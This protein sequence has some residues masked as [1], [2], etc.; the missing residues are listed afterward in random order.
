MSLNA[1]QPEPDHGYSRHPAVWALVM[2]DMRER[3]LV[4]QAKYGTALRP[5]NG[6]DALVD[7]YQEA[8]DLCVYMRQAI[9]ERDGR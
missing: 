8:L 3:D 4:G 9:F 1:I 5:H 6:R 7:A 2:D